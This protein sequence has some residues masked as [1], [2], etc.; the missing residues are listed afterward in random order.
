MKTLACLISAG[1]LL[2]AG[3][4][5]ADENKC[6]CVANGTSYG[7]GE[8]ACLGPDSSRFMARCE[9]N[10]NNT[11]WTKISDVCDVLSELGLPD[12]TITV[13]GIQSETEALMSGP[14]L[15]PPPLLFGHMPAKP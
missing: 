4:A 3:M 15:S 8:V 1:G 11:S 7:Q 9:M 14:A 2:V 12:E 13:A 6:R 10:L 5:A